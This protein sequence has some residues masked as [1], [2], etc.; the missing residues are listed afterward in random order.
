MGQRSTGTY[1]DIAP[2]R[3]Q[4]VGRDNI[5]GY[6]DLGWPTNEFPFSHAGAYM[7]DARSVSLTIS[8]SEAGKR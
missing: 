2:L 4:I 1:F 3:V 8:D 6:F 7:R 5:A